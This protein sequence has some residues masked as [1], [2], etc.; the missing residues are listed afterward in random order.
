[1][2]EASGDHAPIMVSAHGLIHG[3]MWKQTP[4]LFDPLLKYEFHVQH[5]Y[6]QR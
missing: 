4:A 5:H 1:M 6:I 2:F 3:V